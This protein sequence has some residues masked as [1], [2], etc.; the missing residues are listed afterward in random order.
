MFWQV[1]SVEVVQAYVDR[2]QDVNPLINAVIKDRQGPAILLYF[3]FFSS[4][5][6]YFINSKPGQPAA[7]LLDELFSFYSRYNSGS[8]S[9]NKKQKFA[10]IFMQGM[11]ER[12]R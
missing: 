8:L 6:P 3:T 9:F 12:K 10:L 5:S 11:A 7:V 4:L 2:I 1:S